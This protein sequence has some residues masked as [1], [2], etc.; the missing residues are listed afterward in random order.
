VI[1]PDEVS[2]YLKNGRSFVDEEQIGSLLQDKRHT[3]RSLIR[4]ILDKSLSLER[5]E[6]Q[7]T[8]ALLQVDHED[9][10]GEI[11]DAAKQIRNKVYGPRIVTFA[12]LYCSNLCVNSCLYCAFRKENTSEKRRRLSV[13]EVRREAEAL[14]SVGHK[15]L[16]L[17]YGEHPA[18]DIDYIVRTIQAVYDTRVGKG[19]IRRVNVNAAPQS[20]E[21]LKKLKD[22]GIGTFQVFQETY[23]QTTYERVH[24]RGIKA[25]YLWRLY[26]LHRA[27]DAGVD[28]VAI[29]A[30]FG[31]YDWK[32]EV[33][34]LLKHA[35]D[36]EERFGGVGPHTISFPRLEPASNTP[37]CTTSKYRLS[38][39]EFRRVVAVIRVSVPY[40]GMIVTAREPREIRRQSVELGCTQTDA[41]TRIGIGAYSEQYNEQEADRQQFLLGDTRSLDE[42]VREL[43]E[44]GYLTSFCTAGYRCG[45][46]GSHFMTIAKKGNVHLF[47]IPNAI[48][49]LKEFVLDYASPETRRACEELVA[50]RIKHVPENI[51][52]ALRQRLEAIERGE[53]D[54]RF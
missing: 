48:L 21:D 26:A 34:G 33:M 24:P 9:T 16:I 54:L 10:W 18:S 15:R 40:T 41:S 38:D 27:Q 30:L 29:G 36:L 3:G 39:D 5:L 14:V 23:H 44:M 42:L 32:F 49:T 22:V 7:E 4:E 6:P 43:A 8:A 17:V 35:I 53:R 51:V 28:D 12:P 50:R 2:K 37:F 19:E 52:P 31:L 25:D 13:E 46:T 20:I 45:R 47:C 1:K 11:F